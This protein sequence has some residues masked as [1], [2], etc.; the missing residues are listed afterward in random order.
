MRFGSLSV[1]ERGVAFKRKGANFRQAADLGDA[2][3]AVN[4]I[5]NRRRLEAHDEREAAKVATERSKIT[6]SASLDA[7]LKKETP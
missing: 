4:Q 1:G 7:W 6:L 5:N 3:L 2:A